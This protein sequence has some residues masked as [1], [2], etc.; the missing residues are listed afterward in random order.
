[1]NEVEQLR[2]IIQ[3]SDNIVFLAERS[4]HGKPNS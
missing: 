1:M 4:L 2:Q 3:G